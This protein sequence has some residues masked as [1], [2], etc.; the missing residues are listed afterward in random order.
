MFRV[1]CMM[2]LLIATPAGASD[3]PNKPGK[4]PE[5]RLIVGAGA[6]GGKTGGGDFGLIAPAPLKKAT[7]KR[8]VGYDPA[9]RLGN[10]QPNS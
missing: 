8:S 9:A 10:K 5:T 3:F 2:G 7:P 4:K 6:S 1:L